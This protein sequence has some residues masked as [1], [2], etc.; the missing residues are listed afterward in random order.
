MNEEEQKKIL[1]D[2]YCFMI[3]NKSSQKTLV[4]NSFRSPQRIGMTPQIFGEKTESFLHELENRGLVEFR[5]KN[6]DDE[7]EI[8]LTEE[9]RR[10][11]VVVM[12]GGAFDILH[13]G[14][15]ETLKQAKSLGDVLVV[16]VARDS[17][18]ERNRGKKPFH[19][20]HA[21]KELV[22]SV[23]YVDVALLGSEN[24]IFETLELVGPDIVALGYDQSHSEEVIRA[25]IR[26]RG[27][28]T[29]VVRLSSSV[30]KIKTSKILGERGSEILTNL[31]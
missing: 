7:Q 28:A 12:T 27:L 5:K 25:E 30:P 2:I 23:K 22:E 9:G 17:T 3:K 11:F 24:N 21:R 20:E 8:H 18:Y 26:K 29:R 15:I 16:S 13:P 31:D 6:E 4:P 10:K 19:D 14:H 1:C